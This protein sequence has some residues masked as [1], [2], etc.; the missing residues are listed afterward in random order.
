MRAIKE[1]VV[2]ATHGRLRPRS[3]AS[4]KGRAQC[5]TSKQWA[6]RAER[7]AT[8]IISTRQY[9]IPDAGKNSGPKDV[10]WGTPRGPAPA[11]AGGGVVQPSPFALPLPPVLDENT[12]VPGLAF[13][14]SPGYAFD[15][16]PVSTLAYDPTPVFNFDPGSN[17]DS[18]PGSVLDSP[19]SLAFKFYSSASI[20]SYFN[21]IGGKH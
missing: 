17:F 9:G 1:Y 11:G 12:S 4:V 3:G 19:L 8:Q 15:S 14:F 18:D 7:G 21:E 16:E 5:N 2:T 6:A 10:P 20:S 13:D